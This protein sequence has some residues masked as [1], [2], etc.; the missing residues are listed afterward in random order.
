MGVSTGRMSADEIWSFARYIF[1]LNEGKRNGILQIDSITETGGGTT[2]IGQYP[3][4]WFDT[5]HEFEGG[6]DPFGLRPQYGVTLLNVEMNS[7]SYKSGYEIVLD[8]VTNE[9]FLLVLQE[10]RLPGVL[11]LEQEVT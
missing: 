6:D 7:L 3:E 5:W 4:H 2:P 10:V 9:K 1:N 11:L 8:D